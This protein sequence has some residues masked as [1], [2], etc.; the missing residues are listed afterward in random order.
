VKKRI[1]PVAAAMPAFSAAALPPRASTINF[2]LPR[3]A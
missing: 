1:W 3:D 2:T